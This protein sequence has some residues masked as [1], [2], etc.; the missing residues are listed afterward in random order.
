MIRHLCI[1]R[2]LGLALASL[3]LTFPL[4]AISW[5]PSI[6]IISGPTFSQ[7]RTL[8]HEDIAGRTSAFALLDAKVLALGT[9]STT[10]FG[11]GNALLLNSNSCIYQNT[12]LMAFSGLETNLFYAYTIGSFYTL[13][14][15]LGCA[16]NRYRGTDQGFLSLAGRF[17]QSFSPS[18]HLSFDFP[19]SWT[20]RNEVFDYRFGFGISWKPLGGGR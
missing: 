9:N 11:I 19:F 2:V 1:S 17:T 10:R 14:L 3:L 13:C 12:R 20:I 5:S 15:D 8:E 7:N 16:L 4:H 18:P 6:S